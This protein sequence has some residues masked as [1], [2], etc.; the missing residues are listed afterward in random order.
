MI[1]DNICLRFQ[2]KQ[3]GGR[4][5]VDAM[6]IKEVAENSA[7]PRNNQSIVQKVLIQDIFQRYPP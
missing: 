1:C 5:I 6:R 2:D 7:T 3:K 4:L